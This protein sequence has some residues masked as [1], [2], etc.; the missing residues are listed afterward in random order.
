MNI[1][2]YL[3]HPAQYHFFKNVLAILKTKGHTITLLIKTK[4]VL[5][6]LVQNDGY[7]YVNIQRKSRRNNSFSIF[8]AS[9]VRMFKVVLIAKRNHI[10]LLVGTDS[11]IAQAGYICGKPSITTLEDDYD[12]IKKLANLT[13][14]FTSSIVAPAVCS[15]GKWESKKISYQGYMKLA[16]LHPNC[17]TPDINIKMSYVADNKYCLLRLAQLTAHHDTGIKGLNVEIVKSII[18]LA[19]EQGYKV[20]IS[21]ELKIEESLVEYQL[22]INQNDIHHVL[23]FASL[24]ISDSQSMSVEA[25]MLGVPSIRFSD[26]VGRISVLEELENQYKLTFGVQTN[27]VDKLLKLTESLLSDITIA[28]NFQDRKLKMLA[29]KIDV[30][31]FMVWLIENYPESGRMMKE[32]PDYQYQFQ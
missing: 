26:F 28:E 20:Y 16:Y 23:A 10:D 24:L 6:K 19:H 15:V 32:D 31:A 13:Y 5:E 14:P 4:D 9:L 8:I 7:D 29:D 22:K 30:T 18:K 25:A 3:G 27:S 12:V 11:S 17:F 1:L 21:S 2:I